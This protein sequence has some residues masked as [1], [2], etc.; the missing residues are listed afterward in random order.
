MN[1]SILQ[2]IAL[3][4]A[5][6]TQL[7]CS[8]SKPA[9]LEP[10]VQFD[11][12]SSAGLKA[13][14]S[15]VFQLSDI[16]N[17]M[18]FLPDSLYLGELTIPGTHD[19]GAL[20]E[21]VAGTAKTQNLSIAEQLNA[22]VRF[23][24]M[25]CRHFN[26]SFTIHHGA[27]YQHLNFDDVLEACR[28]FLDNHP[29][30]VI[31][32]SVKPEH[33]AVGNTKSFVE[34]FQDYV[35]KDS[36]LWYQQDGVPRLGDSRG[37]IV[38]LRRFS[39]DNFWGIDAGNGWQDQATFQIDRGNYSLHVQDE[40]VVGNNND[41][42]SAVEALLSQAND[43]QVESD[44]FLNFSSGYQQI[45]W[46]IPNIPSVSDDLNPWLVNYFTQANPVGHYGMIAAD[47]MDTNLS[48]KLV[49]SNF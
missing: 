10:E 41:K 19:S 26:D 12:Q 49:L 17:W 46:V 25:R 33:E 3:G 22:G 34:V 7:M 13:N 31:V 37:K 5:L 14:L 8:C 35:D 24:D 36:T 11:M 1:K 38:L 48:E 20:Y 39:A 6:G 47:F 4:F 23:L 28:N 9:L 21:P 42:I 32:M 45:L 16:S 29:D 30:E 27:I 44:L 40:Y 2:K 43:S 18:S 15:P